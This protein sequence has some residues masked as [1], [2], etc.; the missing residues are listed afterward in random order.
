MTTSLKNTAHR[1][2]YAK[3]RC[4]KSL[5][6]PPLLIFCSLK[7]TIIPMRYEIETT[8]I[9]DKWLSKQKDRKAVKA[10]AMRI[11]RAEEGNLGDAEPVGGGVSEMRIFVGKGYR[12]YF[13]I[14][15][16]TVVLLLNG[17]IKSSK[18]QQQI[19]IAQAKRILS[20]IEE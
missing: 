12:I 4:V 9:F 15:G 3:A 5:F 6:I 7:A 10:I 14:R 1:R 2:R 11:A 8:S 18:K 19:D 13:A 16:M 17:G 20:E